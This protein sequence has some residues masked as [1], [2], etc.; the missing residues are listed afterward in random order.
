M[1]CNRP[2]LILQSGKSR[3]FRGGKPVR[4]R[5][6]QSAEDGRTVG[7]GAPRKRTSTV[8][9]P[10]EETAAGSPG[11]WQ[12]GPLLHWGTGRRISGRHENS[13]HRARGSPPTGAGR[14]RS[15]CWGTHDRETSANW[16]S[17]VDPDLPRAGCALLVGDM[18]KPAFDSNGKSVLAGL[19]FA[20]D[21]DPARRV[22][23][24]W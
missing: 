2:R 3:V 22:R 19:Q 12:R 24:Y 10:Q 11:C 21:I 14:L 16:A 4:D 20:G 15:G 7:R 5:G 6:V 1:L 9:L 13:A 23:K 8:A 17:R 18:V